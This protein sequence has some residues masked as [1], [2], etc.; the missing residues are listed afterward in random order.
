MGRHVRVT[1]IGEYI[2]HRSCQRRFRLGYDDGALFEQLPFS[3]KPLHTMDPV[4]AEQ[5]ARREDE[6]AQSLEDAGLANLHDLTGL[7][8]DAKWS[9]FVAAVALLAPGQEGFAR[10]VHT[11]GDV[12]AFHTE[13]RADFLIVRWRDGA[14]H[15]QI[16]ECKA[17]R[18]DRTYHRIQVALYRIL[19]EGHMRRA[20]LVCGG[21]TLTEDAL[22][23]MIVRVDA[24]TNAMIPLDALEPLA[25][26]DHLR[27]DIARL[28]RERGAL[29]RILDTPLDD[30]PFVLDA[31]CDDC[32]FSVHCLPE[33]ARLRRL[34]LLGLQPDVIRALSALGVATLDDLAA[35]DPGGAHAQRIRFDPGFTGDLDALIVR[36]Q[37]RLSTLPGGDDAD[38]EHLPVRRL[39]NRGFGHLPEHEVCDAGAY[40]HATAE[41]LDALPTKQLVRVFLSVSYDY[42]EDRI[43]A[44]AAHVTRSDWELHTPFEQDDDGRW[45]P[46]AGVVEVDPASRRG[47]GEAVTRALRDSY[48]VVSVQ[49]APW[50]TDYRMACGQESNLLQSF[51]RQVVKSIQLLAHNEP[52]PIHFYV[53]SDAEVT[54]LVE[55]AARVGNDMLNFLREL[56]GCRET[57]E[58][59]IYSDLSREV[60]GRHALGWTGRGL[61]V[62]SSLGWYGRYH[63]VREVAG[64]VI[65]LEYELSRDLFD[66]RTRLPMRADQTWADGTEKGATWHRWEVRSRFFDNLSAPYFH[67]YWGRLKAAAKDKTWLAQS[68]RDYNHASEPQMLEGYLT[69]RVQAMRWIEERVS[70]KNR[71]IHKPFLDPTELP[72]FELGTTTSVRAALDFLRL[73]HHVK[74]TEWLQALMVPPYVRVAQGDTVGLTDLRLDGSGDILARIDTATYHT[75]L[76]ALRARVSYHEGGF[77]RLHAAPAQPHEGQT[78]RQLLYYG[79]TCRI[80]ALDWE[81]GEVTLAVIWGDGDRDYYTVTSKGVSDA[82]YLPEYATLDPSITDYVAGKVETRLCAEEGAPTI[83]GSHVERWFDPRRPAIP[84]QVAPPEDELE[85]IAGVLRALRLGEAG[86]ALEERR[87]GIVVDGLRSRVQL[88]QGP[89]GT[90]KSEMTALSVMARVLARREPGDMVFVVA[91]T[92]TAV[93]TLLERVADRRGAFAEAARAAGLELPGLVLAKIGEYRGEHAEIEEV[94]DRPSAKEV[95]GLCARGVLI[96]GGT[97]NGLIKFVNTLDGKKR[98]RAR[99]D[100]GSVQTKLLVIDEASMMVA[101]HFMGVITTLAEDGELLMA[102]DHRQ[103]TP[104]IAHDW[105]HDDR[106]PAQFYRMHE[107]A[108]A[109][110]AT[111]RDPSDERRVR[112]LVGE[113]VRLDRLVRSYRLPEAIRALIQ[114]VY[115]EDGITLEGPAGASLAP[116][117]TQAPSE[118]VDSVWLSGS[119]LSVLVHDEQESRKSNAF[120]ARLIGELVAR[121]VALGAIEEGSVAVVTPHRAQRALLERELAPWSDYITVIDTVERLQGGEQR[122]IIVSATVSDPVAMA[123][124]GEFVL[125]LQRANVAFSRTK[126]RLLVVASEVLFEHI[127]AEV[128][129]YATARLWKH[130]RHLCGERVC[131]FDLDGHGV[132]AFTPWVSRRSASGPGR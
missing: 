7:P 43:G 9:D 3:G 130:L 111:L 6:W 70:P 59:L 53:W 8:E 31:K 56:F 74:Y 80:T 101:A 13:G 113:S 117:V 83:R 32:K 73:D 92:H 14:P 99:F 24:R 121:G 54:R 123:R 12:G 46:Q 125:D 39:P 104:I 87:V 11:S 79:K 114:P 105:E 17:S 42:A 18:K 100:G 36:A 109:A 85:A 20:P 15:L 37:A 57:L 118:P 19:I 119:S 106:P 88:I 25:E 66:F 16:V 30:L 51:F 76:E 50:S 89:P 49:P 82:G 62:V 26:L 129:V 120:E 63:W 23:C 68:I 131:G 55:S 132:Q 52:A 103:L 91:N 115:D 38:V 108:F 61:T 65:D 77:A 29:D 75:T 71:S 124:S 84:P 86:Y 64:E 47:G 44:L 28:M 81:T 98:F 112:D 35:L 127:P 95:D 5:G 21:V 93:E 96:V 72:V 122:T 110:I 78:M 116:A 94:R 40:A 97:T 128:E 22:S 58:Q 34:H 48:D 2:R 102:G 126:E 107:S 69:A 4:L 60:D 67:A 41:E 27:Q 90:G 1:D 10:E 33:S 45:R